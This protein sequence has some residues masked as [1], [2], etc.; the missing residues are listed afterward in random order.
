MTTPFSV[1]IHGSA[2]TS[3]T[4]KDIDVVYSG[5]WTADAACVARQ[6][7]EKRKLFDVPIDAHEST[8]VTSDGQ[9]FI[10]IPHVPGCDA[11]YEVI[12]G[13]PRVC[14]REYSGLA[15]LLRM[16]VPAAEICKRIR[17]QGVR[18]GLV[19]MDDEWSSYVDGATALKSAIRH[20]RENGTWDEILHA[21]PDAMLLAETVSCLGTGKLAA[22]ILAQIERG[23]GWVTIGRDGVTFAERHRDGYRW[24]ARAQ[25][26]AEEIEHGER[27]L[28]VDDRVLVASGRWSE[29]YEG[30][31]CDARAG[32]YLVQSENDTLWIEQSHLAYLGDAT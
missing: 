21:M 6:W 31:V 30:R 1:V 27:P 20:A 11:V 32:E 24:W 14:P 2:L 5:G 18:I 7:A 10:L 23:G 22:S 26:L 16:R 3:T 8:A 25:Y 12:A 29:F 28:A 9:P 4:P 17:R 19:G 13:T 15:S